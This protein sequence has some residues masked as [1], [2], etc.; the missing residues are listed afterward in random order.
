MKQTHIRLKY[1]RDFNLRNWKEHKCWNWSILYK[2]RFCQNTRI[3]M[4][5]NMAF[6]NKWNSC[7]YIP[8]LQH[9]MGL[10]LLCSERLLNPHSD[11]KHDSLHDGHTTHTTQENTQKHRHDFKQ[12]LNPQ[13][14]CSRH[15]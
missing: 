2:N 4:A 15:L 11:R 8:A 14:H 10:V 6:L 12:D 9:N 7:L 5:G 3:S 1:F 13:F